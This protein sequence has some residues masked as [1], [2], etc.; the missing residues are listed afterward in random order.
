MRTVTFSDAHVAKLVSEHFVSA[1]FNRG[2]GFHNEDYSAEQW[3]AAKSTYPTRNICTFFMTPEGMLFDYVA[4]Y[5]EPAVFSARLEST[6]EIRK[7][8]PDGI[9]AVR[10]AHRR[11]AE[12]AFAG[13]GTI[14][15]RG[16]RYDAARTS[17]GYFR[18]LHEHWSRVETLPWLDE[19]R[20]DY[21][22]GNSFTEE[23]RDATG[24]G[25]RCVN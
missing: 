12:R 13:G 9:D 2:P 4:G 15:Y 23:S 7:A 5:H 25:G 1:W 20:F 8:L 3:I 6:I 11:A 18:A 24:V 22:Y 14:E 19:V 16:A 17:D 21:L 10:A